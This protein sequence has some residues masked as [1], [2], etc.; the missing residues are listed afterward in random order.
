MPR[1]IPVGNGQLL[2]NF[3]DKYRLRDI[4]YPQVGLHNHT[5]GNIQRFGIWV[6][7][8]FSWI[9]DDAWTRS[10]RYKPD[11]M[12][13]EVRLK[14]Q[15]IGIELLCNDAVDYHSPV[16]FRKVTIVD[17]HGK[18]RNVRVF[19]HQD[20][21][22]NGSPVGDTANYDPTTAGL[23]HYKDDTYF[24]INACDELRCGIDHWTTGSK[25]IGDAEG[26]WRD[27]E[28]GQLSHNTIAQGSVD[29]TVGFNLQLKA[30]GSSTLIYWIAVGKDYRSVKRLNQ[31]IFKKSPQR[32]MDRTEAYWRLWACKEPVQFSMPHLSSLQG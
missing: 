11:S 18:P 5:G 6:D 4:Y 7:G 22:V 29:S 19:F 9:E 16:F 32:M 1:D 23:I 21:S 8:Q 17:L 28:D 2:V 30:N 14:N 24:L 25:R 26:T 3:D 27:A 10:L 31:K 15:Q 20:I 12:I 13:T